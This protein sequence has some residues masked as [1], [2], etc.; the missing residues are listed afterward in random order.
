MGSAACV[1]KGTGMREEDFVVAALKLLTRKPPLA[2][3]VP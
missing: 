3:A 1:G 2:L